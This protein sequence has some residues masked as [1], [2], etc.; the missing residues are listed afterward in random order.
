MSSHHD[1]VLSDR[2]VRQLDR[3]LQNSPLGCATLFKVN[4][5]T[6]IPFGKLTQHAR[7]H[8]DKYLLQSKRLALISIGGPEFVPQATTAGEFYCAVCHET[9]DPSTWARHWNSARHRMNQLLKHLRQ[10]GGQQ[11]GTHEP[12]HIV[13]S[14]L[15]ECYSCSIGEQ[16]DQELHVHNEGPPPITLHSFNMLRQNPSFLLGNEDAWVQLVFVCLHKLQAYGIAKEV[17]F[18]D[19][20]SFSVTRNAHAECRIQAPAGVNLEP[21]A[22]FNFKKKRRFEV[23]RYDYIAGQPPPQSN[24][25]WRNPPGQ[26]KP[27]SWMTKAFQNGRLETVEARVPCQV[28]DLTD[29]SLKMKLL[30][31]AEELQHEIDVRMYDMEGVE[32]RKDRSVYMSLSVPGLAENRPSVMRG[33]ALYVRF[34]DEGTA[35]RSG[36]VLCTWLS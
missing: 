16:V 26:Q 5:G 19:F 21:S 6:N 2:K 17:I 31:W 13:V 25:K 32:L 24:T 36:K 34:A 27:P 15:D 3:F 4:S 22:P 35:Q 28:N 29:Y 7:L 20:G 12:M 11:P 30:L 23:P 18:L 14:K 33:D 1:G 9:C 8:P 10:N